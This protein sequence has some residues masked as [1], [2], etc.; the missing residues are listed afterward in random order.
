MTLI[1]SWQDAEAV[2]ADHARDL[3]FLD[4]RLTP[5]GA[6]GGIDVIATGAVAQVKHYASPVGIAEVQ[7]LRGTIRGG[8]VAIFYASAGYTASAIKFAEE[9]DLPLFRFDTD[10]MVLPV[11][12]RAVSMD[13][14]RLTSL[15]DLNSRVMQLWAPL[16][17]VGEHMKLFMNVVLEHMTPDNELVITQSQ[18]VSALKHELPEEYVTEFGFAWL[19]FVGEGGTTTTLNWL[20]PE[21]DR[22]TENVKDFQLFL[23]SLPAPSVENA[24]SI[25]GLMLEAARGIVLQLEAAHARLAEELPVPVTAIP[26]GP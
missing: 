5:A 3:G 23:D 11:T 14:E 19:R 24:Q 17:F 25:I 16:R 8:E 26:T 18:L 2:A 7:R 1:N 4:A 12:T 15:R 21:I 9:V 20:R 6:D 10:G 13:V 22:L